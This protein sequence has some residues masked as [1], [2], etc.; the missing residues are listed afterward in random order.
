VKLIRSIVDPG[1]VSDI[2]DALHKRGVS[3]LTL[4]EV[5]DHAPEK[6]QTL[7]VWRGRRF[8]TSF[9]EKIEID[10]V[11]HDDDVDDIVSIILGTARKGEVGEGHVSVMP[12]E[13]R[14]N[15]RTGARDVN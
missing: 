11:V 12:I 6:L 7:L 14:Y 15:I 9:F 10:V 13:H 5:R 2:K 8:T 4:T 1:K 3:G